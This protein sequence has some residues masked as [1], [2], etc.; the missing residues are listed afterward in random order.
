MLKLAITGKPEDNTN[1]LI[2]EVERREQMGPNIH[3]L[4]VYHEN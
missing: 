4:V 1:Q 3:S 2:E